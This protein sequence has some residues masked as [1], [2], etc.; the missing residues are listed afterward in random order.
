MSAWRASTPTEARAIA[1]ALAG[2]VA[3]GAVMLAPI[4]SYRH[5]DSALYGGDTRLNAWALAWVDHAVLGRIPVFEANIFFP[6]LNT[7]AYSEHLLGISPFALPVYALTRNAALSYNVVWLL[8]Y[9]A[10]A[11]A[12][13]ALAWRV[14][15]D[16]FASWVGGL[17]YAFCF[18]RML[19]GH[20]HLQLL[21]ACWIPASLLLVERWWRAPS[22]PRLMS[23]WLVV[24]VQVLTSWYLAV[25][26]LLADALFAIW[27][28]IWLPPRRAMRVS[29]ALQLA[30]AAAAGAALVW[31]I[32]RRYEFLVGLNGQGPGEALGGAIAWRDLVVPPLNTWLGQW[33][34][35]RGSQAPS[36]IWGEKTLFLGYVTLALG[37][38]GLSATWWT[39]SSD[40][41]QEQGDRKL[42]LGFLS[43]LSL[44]A[45][46]LAFGPSADAVARRSFDWTPFGLL[47]TVPGVSLFRVPARFVQLVTLALA[48]FAA[49]GAATLHARLGRV[50]RVL[51]LLLV[52]VMLAEWYLVDFPGGAPQAERVPAIYRQLARIPAHAVVSLPE[53]IGGPEWF[54]EADYQVL[55]DDPLA[56]HRERLLAHRA[57]RLSRADVGDFHLPEPRER[58]GAAGNWRRLCGAAY[59]ALSRRRRRQGASRLVQR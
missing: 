41:A 49:A 17:A 55:R 38:L 14:T 20:A 51:T 2:Y 56:S 50:G 23:L 30:A 32:A 24:L 28:V 1:W 19:H 18:Y 36:W 40:E 12:A 42:W 39:A 54:N 11:L 16:R 34:V 9:L 31:P 48:V 35:H 27:L 59:Q 53:Y 6:A 52:P 37:A 45:L 26:V 10:C 13:Y 57:A 4:T 44:V 3:V 22:W 46:V 25:M 5:L 8:S 47:S 15:H 58:R 33:L 29:M 21:W 43:L 7:L